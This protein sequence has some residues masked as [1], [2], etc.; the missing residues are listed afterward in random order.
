MHFNKYLYVLHLQQDIEIIQFVELI[1][2]IEIQLAELK[3]KS[4]QQRHFNNFPIT[5]INKKSQYFIQ[6]DQVFAELARIT[7]S[8]TTTTV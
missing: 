1:Q 2:L 3:V 5:E 7:L 8:T 6:V 4:H